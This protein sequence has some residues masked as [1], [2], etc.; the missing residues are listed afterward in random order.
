MRQSWS[1][2]NLVDFVVESVRRSHADDPPF[3][4][5]RFD[6]VFRSKALE[7][8]FI[9]RLKPGLKRRFGADFAKVPMYSVPILTRDV[10]GYY[11]TAHSDTLWKGITVQFYLPADNSTPV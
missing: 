8:V 2:N 4:H 9:E 10:P 7:K 11:M 3:Y 5:L 1:V 6:R